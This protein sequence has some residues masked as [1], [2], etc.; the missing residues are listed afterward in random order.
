MNGRF[1][2]GPVK[3]SA[4][5][6]ERMVWGKLAYAII[7]GVGS[8]KVSQRD[9]SPSPSRPESSWKVCII[10]IRK[11]EAKVPYRPFMGLN[12]IV[13]FGNIIFCWWVMI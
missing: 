7:F 5:R 10:S 6:I 12:S 1:F 3:V 9:I 8:T 2:S 13:R 11:R 4:I